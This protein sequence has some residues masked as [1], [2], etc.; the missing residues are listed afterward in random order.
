MARKVPV[1]ANRQTDYERENESEL[2]PEN[3]TVE[4][5]TPGSSVKFV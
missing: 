5:L 3:F 2:K 4:H 1:Y